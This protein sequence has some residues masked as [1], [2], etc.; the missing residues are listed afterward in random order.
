MHNATIGTCKP[1]AGTVL[2]INL[3]NVYLAVGAEGAA[4]RAGG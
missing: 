2:E 3:T 4:G 1:R